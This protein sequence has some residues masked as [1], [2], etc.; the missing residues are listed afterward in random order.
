MRNPLGS[1]VEAF[2]F[3]LLTVAAFAAIALASLLGG[4]WAGVPTFA[5]VTGAAA[6]FYLRRGRGSGR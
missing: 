6:F 3:L 2:H 5:V 4:P 1:E